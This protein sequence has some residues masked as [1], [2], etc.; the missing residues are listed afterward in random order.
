MITSDPDRLASVAASLGA[1]I[2]EAQAGKRVR[3]PVIQPADAAGLVM[4]MHAQLDAAI[5][6]R[7]AEAVELGHH[8]ACSAGCSACC[9]SPLLVS[10]GEA[11][12]VAVWLADQPA[13][14][15]QFD[16]A[17]PAWKRGVGAAGAALET[18]TSDDERQAAARTLRKQHVMCAFNREGLCTIYDA[19]PARCRKVHALGSNAA[20]GPDGDGQVQYFE[21][22]ATEMTFEEQEPMRGALHHA[23]HPHGGLELLCS[24]VHRMVHART[25]RNSPCPCGSGKKHKH[26]CAA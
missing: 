8:L 20:C 1:A 9:A 18:A 7:T 13:I 2:R 25:P 26:C 17:Y 14:A 23:L 6:E 12:T 22:V 4:T 24:S 11:V 3:L 19:R 16:A 21:H 5:A 15:A 10:A